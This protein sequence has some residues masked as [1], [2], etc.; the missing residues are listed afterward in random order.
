RFTEVLFLKTV[1][2]GILCGAAAWLLVEA[3]RLSHRLFDRLRER[4]H[5]WPPLLPVIGAA[6]MAGLL[7]F[8]PL[9]YVGLSLP[10]MHQALAGEAVPYAGFAWKILLVA[11]TLGSGFYGGIVTPQF[12]IG[13]V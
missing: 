3:L 6:L 4:F 2:I 13:A 8:V 9:D 10:V 11:I 7:W 12:V 1:L 5:L